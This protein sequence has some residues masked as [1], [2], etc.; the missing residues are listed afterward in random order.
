MAGA[1]GKTASRKPWQR[2]QSPPAPAPPPQV[3]HEGVSNSALR[4]YSCHRHNQTLVSLQ[5]QK[6]SR[7][8]VRMIPRDSSRNW[9]VTSEYWKTSTNGS[10]MWILKIMQKSMPSHVNVKVVSRISTSTGNIY[11]R[12]QCQRRRDR[13]RREARQ[14]P[15]LRASFR[16][17]RQPG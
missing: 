12:W 3:L 4:T 14:M 10:S 16:H 8:G 6:S 15:L 5:T 2:R 7:S 13:L 1:V 17:Q 9:S 11:D